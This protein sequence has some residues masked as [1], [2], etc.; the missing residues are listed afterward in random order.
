V[1]VAKPLEARSLRGYGTE[2]DRSTPNY[3]GVGRDPPKF[4]DAGARPFGWGKMIP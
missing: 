2:F 3:M 4:G 1:G